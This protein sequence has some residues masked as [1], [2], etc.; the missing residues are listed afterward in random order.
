VD[1]L[2]HDIQHTLGE[3]F[4]GAGRAAAQVASLFVAAGALSSLMLPNTRRERQGEA[5]VIGH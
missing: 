4:S 2:S 1:I 5:L 3:G